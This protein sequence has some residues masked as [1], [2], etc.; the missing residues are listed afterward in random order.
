MAQVKPFNYEIDKI[1][2]REVVYDF[3]SRLSIGRDFINK[4]CNTAAN[5]NDKQV[6]LPAGMLLKDEV[7]MNMI[8]TMDMSDILHL[9]K[10]KTAYKTITAGTKSVSITIPSGCTLYRIIQEKTGQD[11][12]QCF[13]KSGNNYVTNFD[14][15]SSHADTYKA[16][17]YTA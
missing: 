15:P 4:D 2:E 13:T 17:Y 8:R 10:I 6:I 11:V 16:Y 14:V 1:T 5:S 9:D 3:V 7:L 12:T